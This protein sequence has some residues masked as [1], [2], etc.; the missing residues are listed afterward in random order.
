MEVSFLIIQTLSIGK[1][2]TA[3]ERISQGIPVET[4][5]VILIYNHSSDTRLAFGSRIYFVKANNKVFWHFE[6]L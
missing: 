2:N 6:T 1:N 3:S 5:E 4:L